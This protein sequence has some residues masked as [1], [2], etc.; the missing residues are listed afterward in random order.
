MTDEEREALS[1]AEEEPEQESDGPT[2]IFGQP[3]EAA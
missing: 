1:R 2:D 3:K